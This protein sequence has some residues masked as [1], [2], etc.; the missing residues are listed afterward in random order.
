MKTKVMLLVVMLL[1]CGA[2]KRATAQGK[3]EKMPDNK[4]A[5][6][7]PD[8]AVSLTSV[9]DTKA[10][11]TVYNKCKAK[12]GPSSVF[13]IIYK[14]ATKSS[15][16]DLYVGNDLSPL[17]PGEKINVTITLGADS[18][19]KS[20]AGRFLRVVVD[21]SNTVKEASEG[22][23]WWEPNAQPFPEKVGYCDPPYSK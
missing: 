2:V 11:V 16:A 20:F 7:L 19:V 4:L 23:N 18:K 22:N 5:R 13:I 3:P 6:Y 15:G 14:G 1:I 12:A 17:A 21:Q 10:V 9:S 8:L